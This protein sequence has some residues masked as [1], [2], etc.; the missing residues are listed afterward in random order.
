MSFDITATIRPGQTL[1]RYL[2]FR[3]PD[4][5]TKSSSPSRWTTSGSDAKSFDLRFVFEAFPGK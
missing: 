2:V 4:A 3:S 5:R 1:E